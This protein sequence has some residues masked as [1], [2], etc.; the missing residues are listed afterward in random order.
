MKT[1]AVFA[2]KKKNTGEKDCLKYKMWL[3]KKGNHTFLCYESNFFEVSDNR[4][5]IDC[6]TIHITKT[7]QAFLHLWKPNGSEQYICF[8]NRICSNVDGVGTYRL[9][10]KAVFNLIVKTLYVPSFSRNLI[11]LSRLSIVG[12]DSNSH[13]FT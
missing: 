9:I 11:S 3:E 8:G 7:M 13:H 2:K 1:Y 4:W 6:G 10:L 5:E 12:F